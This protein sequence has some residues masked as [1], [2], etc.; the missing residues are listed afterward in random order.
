MSDAIEKRVYIGGLHSSV[1]DQLLHDRFN[2]YG[3]ISS[4]TVAKDDQGSCRGFGHL[5]ITTTPKQ[6]AGC[7]SVYNG[8]KWKGMVMRLEDA[9]PDY[10]ERKR[11]EDDRLQKE[12]K[13]Q[14]KKRL[15]LERLSMAKDM[16]PVTDNNMEKRRGWSRGKYGRAIAIM[17][18]RRPDGTQIVFDPS[19]Y[20][21]NLTKLYN[22]DAR[23]KPVSR[24]PMQYDDYTGDNHDL[25]DD[26]IDDHDRNDHEVNMDKGNEKRLAAMERRMAEAQQKHELISRAL[27]G[28]GKER[29][30]HVTFDN[31]GEEVDQDDE[32]L[33]PRP[34]SERPAPR[35]SNWLFDS[36][37]DDDDLEIKMNPVLEGEKGRERL[38]LQ[39]TFKGDERFKLDEDFIDED[40][41]KKTRDNENMEEDE[42]TRDLNAEKDQ[43]MDVLRA[44]FGEDTVNKTK[45]KETQWTSGARY[46]PDAEDADQYLRNAQS[47]EEE[48]DHS[49]EEALPVNTAPVTAMPV[50][51]KDKH[52][53]VNVNMKPLFAAEEG[54]F[55][56][57]GGDDD[58]D[59]ENDT[60]QQP[61][62]GNMLDSDEEEEVTTS[63]SKKHAQLGLGLMFF[64][65]TNNPSL[66]AKSCFDYDPNGVFQR[67][68]SE[69]FESIWQEKRPQITDYLKKRQKRALKRNKKQHVKSSVQ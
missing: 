54:P 11:K 22:I 68:E 24:L 42:I 23:M 67:S 55:K 33:E 38:A 15:R 1:T 47:S 41:T 53:E 12:E 18:L 45:K 20:K 49:E 48:N 61:L 17:H 32:S 52:F 13:R 39:S 31:E 63:K 7:L 34:S 10:K 35:D 21:N 25:Y 30:N 44:M 65:H 40:E 50:V 43:S 28:D 36:D 60:K 6:W 64:F 57:F 66:M 51:S 5:T 19:H 37:E 69:D 8:A 2:R 16:T 27:S 29:T 9:K 56:L 46:D 59:N 14:Q 26:T 62:F 3:T 58:E 4:A